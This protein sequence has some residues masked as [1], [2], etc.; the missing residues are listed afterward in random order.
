MNRATTYL[1][2]ILICLPTVAIA[3]D[4]TPVPEVVN[5]VNV[6]ELPSTQGTAIV[7]SLAPGERA[8]IL[9]A[10]ANWYHV[11]LQ[12]GVKGFVSKR[13]V[14][15]VATPAIPAA[16]HFEL[17]MVDV[18]NGDGLLLDVGDKEILIDG[19]MFPKPLASY[20][21]ANALISG[22]IELA[23]VTHADSDHWKGMSAFL[24]L[25]QRAPTHTVLE[26]WE[27]GFDRGCNPLDSYDDFISGMRGLVPANKFARPLRAAH[28]PA[29]ES[30]SPQP[31][32]LSSIAEVTI[33]V[34]HAEPGPAGHSCPFKINNASIVLKIEIGGVSMLLT[35][36]ANGKTRDEPSSITPGHVEAR[37]LGLERQHPG[38]LK[39]DVLKVGHHGSETAST[40]AFIAA[41][42]PKFAIISAST[43][44][45]L[46]DP[47]VV[48]R[49]EDAGAIVLRTDRSRQREDDP[50]ICVGT[51]A[52]EI[53]CNYADEFQ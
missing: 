51:G 19:G 48:R 44:H 18:G 38:T 45:H 47:T 34:L 39:A 17:H 5:R 35:G 11:Q 22:P 7:G 27:P 3:D 26:F 23:I 28:V 14:A 41:V 53:D 32:Q 8:T 50:I 29:D 6:R 25:D 2:A 9:E 30:G 46:P 52:G 20:L 31:F 43:P 15:I 21:A 24:G 33:T 12:S 10:I 40:D 36:D 49:Y 16:V 1:I 37:L 4:V 13:W 42:K